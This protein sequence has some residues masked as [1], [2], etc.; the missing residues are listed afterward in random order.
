M[1]SRC[2]YGRICSTSRTAFA[3]SFESTIAVVAS[4]TQAPHRNPSSMDVMARRRRSGSWSALRERMLGV[5]P[6]QLTDLAVR[7]CAR[8][9]QP[10]AVGFGGAALLD[11]RCHDE[12]GDVGL[13]GFR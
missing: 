3:A 4:A 10:Q 11:Q 12:A 1:Q 2:A 5:D 9:E 6:L 13:D 7:A 8:D